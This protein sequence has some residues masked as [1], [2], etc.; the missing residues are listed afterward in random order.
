MSRT[1]LEISPEEWVRYSPARRRKAAPHEATERAWDQARAAGRVLREQFGATRVVVFGSLAHQLW[2][3]ADS[4]IDLAVWGI[5]A[6]V[7]VRAAAAASRAASD[8]E[9]NLVDPSDCS[10]ALWEEIE[11]QGIDI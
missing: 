9:I 3:S 5:A 6:S 1:A 11:R 4:D 2:F 7:F 8:R 10:D